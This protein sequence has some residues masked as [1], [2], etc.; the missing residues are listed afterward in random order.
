MASPL[1]KDNQTVK[2]ISFIYYKPHIVILY[3]Q[4]IEKC[5]YIY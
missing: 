3:I 4:K 1:M 2:D 5:S